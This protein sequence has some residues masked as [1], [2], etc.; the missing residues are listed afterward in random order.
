MPR[1]SKDGLGE[2]KW[3]GGEMLST[4]ITVIKGLVILLVCVFCLYGSQKWLL[5]YP[6]QN[7][8]NI[9]N[10]YQERTHSSL[11]KVPL[12]CIFYAVLSKIVSDSCSGKIVWALCVHRKG[13]HI[14]LEKLYSVFLTETLSQVLLSQIQDLKWCIHNGQRSAL[15]SN[16]PENTV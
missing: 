3:G 5:D 10:A 11:N 8:H 15:W 4:Y 16:L 13:C 12:R 2:G 6:P 9:H 7:I 1:G 14:P